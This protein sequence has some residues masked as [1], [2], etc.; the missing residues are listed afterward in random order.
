MSFNVG[1]FGTV[2]P[3]SRMGVDFGFRKSLFAL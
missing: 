3:I 2:D 1:G